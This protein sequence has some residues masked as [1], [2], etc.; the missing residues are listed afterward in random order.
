M[1]DVG[2]YV[3]IML[4]QDATMLSKEDVESWQD[5]FT[6][7]LPFRKLLKLMQSLS[8]NMWMAQLHA[9]GFLHSGLCSV[10]D[11]AL[12]DV[13]TL[14]QQSNDEQ[15]LLT[16]NHFVDS[17]SYARM[18]PSLTACRRQAEKHLGRLSQRQKMQDISHRYGVVLQGG[19]GLRSPGIGA[20]FQAKYDSMCAHKPACLLLYILH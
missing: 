3:S 6:R 8:L 20:A 9:T 14:W 2:H 13:D 5:K 15:S 10:R 1:C 7:E 12:C 19:F 18:M 17:R 16:S 11:L 4:L